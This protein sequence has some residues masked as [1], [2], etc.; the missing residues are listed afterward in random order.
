MAENITI[1]GQVRS[2]DQTPIFM[3]K[4]T[5][6]RDRQNV[7]HVFT[8]E[9]GKYTISVPMGEPIT[10]RF[11]THHSITNAGDWHP[12]VVANVDATHDIVL[13]RFL[14]RVGTDEG[15]Q[16]GFVD[17][18]TAYQFCA[19]WTAEG[20]EPEYAE[21]AVRRLGP[22][23]LTTRVLQDIRQVLQEHFVKQ[24]KAQP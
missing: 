5:V 14:L 17:A 24:I 13:N 2:Y 11:D 19:M 1:S 7:A 8:N 15:G 3:I 4:V 20:L 22:F 21:S 6:Y 10:V 16:T 18:L 9:E 12:S 23:K